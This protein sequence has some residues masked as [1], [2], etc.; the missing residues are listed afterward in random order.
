MKRICLLLVALFSFCLILS[1]CSGGETGGKGSKDENGT[2]IYGSNVET[3]LI[4]S[5]DLGDDT[6][7]SAIKIIADKVYALTGNYPYI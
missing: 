7:S 1:S 5:L 2:M 3:S 6:N 4:T